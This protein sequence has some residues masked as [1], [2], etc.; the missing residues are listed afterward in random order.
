M[1]AGL[2]RGSYLH[3]LACSRAARLAG[4][5]VRIVAARSRLV[6]RTSRRGTLA[7]LRCLAVRII[8]GLYAF[9]MLVR[10]VVFGLHPDAAYPDSYY[11][12]DVA[13][14]LQAGHGFNID[15]IYSFL[16]VGGRIPAD[17]HL[18]IASNGFWMPLASIIQLPTIWLFGPVPLASAL[19]FM[20]IG[21]LTAPLT[22][23]IAREVGARPTVAIAAALAV[24]LPAATT[25]YV[26][27]PDNIALY[28]PIGLAA[29]WLTARGLKGH[30]RSFALAGLA[31]G[32]GTLARND[33]LLLGAM[34]GLAFLWDRSGSWRPNGTRPPLIPWRFAAASLAL[35]AVVTVPWYLRQ[36][37]VF[38]TISP[39]S[40][41]SLLAQNYRDTNCVTCPIS[42]DHLLGQGIGPLLASRLVGLLAA[43][44][45]FSAMIITIVLVPFA[46][47]GARRRIR[48]T[49]F[50]PF[51]LYAGILFG[52]SSL[53]FAA[54]VPYGTFLHS[55]VALAPYAFIL[56][57]EGS[58]LAAHWAVRHR[59]SWT[60]EGAVRLFLVVAAASI[61]IDAMAFTA[62]AM[63]A[64]NRDR[65]NRVAAGQALDAAGVPSTDLLLSADPAGF[66]YFTGRGG[67]VTPNDSLEIIQEVAADYDIRWL[68]LERDHIVEPMYP[69][70]ESK[71]RPAWI[72]PPIFTVPDTGPK[73][74]D[75][76]ANA[77]PALAI[78]PI[79]TRPGDTRCS[80]PLGARAAP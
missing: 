6:I 40:G 9:A 4:L 38:G 20:L 76:A 68:V 71:S 45:I 43:I 79:C 36:L 12:V 56:A 53:L 18:P 44:A 10:A 41:S 65:D 59:P 49:D 63:P 73:S 26:A 74:N 60:V 25:L 57:F 1:A 42:I 58:A 39:S 54:Y 61:V 35:F 3:L 55:A 24:A 14:A 15:F 27:Q 23:L 17:P 77:A 51:F 34:V 62:M 80:A 30:R 48:S 78:Y 2:L 64:W 13:R 67:V 70:I 19:P 22:W 47:A 37:V 31:V 5:S 32:L 72:G 52:A 75:A 8:I 16:D 21:A 66:K 69:V 11:Y 7:M 29:M 28:Q 46:I 50:G 33:G